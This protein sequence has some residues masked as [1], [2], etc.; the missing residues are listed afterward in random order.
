MINILIWGLYCVLQRAGAP[1]HTPVWDAEGWEVNLCAGHPSF[2]RTGVK[3]HVCFRL[4][5]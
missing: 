2:S 1:G 3:E 5:I 4:S